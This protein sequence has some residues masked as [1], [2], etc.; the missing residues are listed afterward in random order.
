MARKLGDIEY[1]QGFRF[2]WSDRRRDNGALCGWFFR[3][4]EEDDPNE[5][6]RLWIM[7]FPT[8]DEETQNYWVQPGPGEN[9]GYPLPSLD[10][11]TAYFAGWFTGRR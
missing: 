11:A 8:Q 4:D 9:P 5:T 7:E 2:E 10:M 6:E 3:D 1:A